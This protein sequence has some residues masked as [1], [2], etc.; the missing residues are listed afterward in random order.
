MTGQRTPVSC[1]HV[2]H[3]MCNQVV[4]TCKA[5]SCAEVLSVNM[6]LAPCC[7]H[8]NDDDD[9]IDCIVCGLYGLQAGVEFLH[10]YSFLLTKHTMIACVNSFGILH[11]EEQSL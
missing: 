11:T 4:R 2:L 1:C 8:L 9:K 7:A 3:H 10:Y 5:A 6:S